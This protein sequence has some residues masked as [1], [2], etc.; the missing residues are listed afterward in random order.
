MVFYKKHWMSLR[1]KVF[2]LLGKRYFIKKVDGLHLLL[3]I[4]NRVD[5]HI[6]AF[7]QY[8]K[9]QT[10]FLFNKLKSA[11]CS[12]FID[13]GSH[14]GYYSLLFASHNYFDRADIYAFEPDS[15][16]RNQLNANLFLNKLQDRIKVYDYALSNQD[17]TLFFHHFDENNRGRSCIAEDGEITVQTTR[18][19]SVLTL[20]GQM[21]GIKVDVEGHELDV[22]SG[23]QETL[24]NNKCIIQIESFSEMLPDLLSVMSKLNYKNIATIDSDHYFSNENSD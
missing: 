7:S 8:E 1:K 5:R 12:C 9:S 20:K 23:M 10:D 18:L 4:K 24:K 19:D 14:W 22:I 2:L 6:D 16:N 3:D 13:I 11:Q 21:L 15:I 17:G